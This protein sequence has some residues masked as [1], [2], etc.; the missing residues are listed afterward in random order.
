ME[1]SVTRTSRKRN[2]TVNNI[3]VATHTSESHQDR[4]QSGRR[5]SIYIMISRLAKVRP[6]CSSDRQPV[7]LRQFLQRDLRPRADVLDDFGRR[8]RAEPAGVFVARRRAPARTGIRRRTDRRRRWYRP[9]SSI[10]N[11]GTAMTPSFDATTQPF[12]LRVTTPS[13][14]RPAQLLQRGVEIR[15]LVQRMQFGL[16]GENQ[17]D[18]AACAS[19]REIRRDSDRRKTNPTGSARPGG[20]HHARWST[21]FTKASLALFGSHR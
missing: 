19:G 12:S 18:G 10:G 2:Y 14:H 8:Q 5:G 4:H 20:P 21:A 13:L 6:L 11:A 9:A 7:L 1:A 17:V 3:G 16:V 15:G